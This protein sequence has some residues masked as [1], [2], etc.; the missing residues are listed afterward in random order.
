MSVC[1]S[2][3]SAEL[4]QQFPSCNHCPLVEKEWIAG[5]ENSVRKYVSI[6]NCRFLKIL[7]L[8]LIVFTGVDSL[9]LCIDIYYI[10]QARPQAMDCLWHVLHMQ[11]H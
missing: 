6:K 9:F 3:W 7:S 8:L 5:C 10:S 1:M 11:T 4:T 2:A